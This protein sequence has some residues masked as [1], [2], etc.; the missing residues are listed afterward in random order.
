MTSGKRPHRSSGPNR[1]VSLWVAAFLL[2]TS[3]IA[4]PVL[5]DG[6]VGELAPDFALTNTAGELVE[7]DFGQGEVFL[8][9]FIGYS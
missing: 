1:L 4:G 5:A 8:L 6:Q 7:I 9:N 3:A 2:V